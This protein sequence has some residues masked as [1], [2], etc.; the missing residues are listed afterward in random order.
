MV[1]AKVQGNTVFEIIILD[2]KY[3]KPA[4]ML[5]FLVACYVPLFA[6]RPLPLDF[7]FVFL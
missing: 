3:L 4:F 5:A 7:I 1:V 6:C 2:E